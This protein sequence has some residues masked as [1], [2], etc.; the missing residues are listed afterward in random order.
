MSGTGRE[1]DRCEVVVVGA[2]IA[3]SAL[4]ASLARRGVRVALLERLPVFRDLVRG[5]M[6]SP[7]GVAES[8]L[9]GVENDLYA[10]NPTLLRKWVQW[11][12][13]HAPDE[14]PMVDLARPAVPG[15]EGPLSIFHHLTCERFTAVAEAA[16]ARVFMGVTDLD[17]T[18]GAHPS[19][20]FTSDGKHSTIDTRLVVGAGG[21]GGPVRRQLGIEVTRSVHHWGAG[22]AVKGLDDW[23][24]GVQ[25][26]GTEGSR[27]FFVFP[28][29]QGRA[30]LYLNF[31]TEWKHKCAGPD[32]PRTFLKLFGLKSMPLSEMIVSSTPVGPCASLPS[33]IS[34]VATIAGPGFVLVGDEAGTNDTVLGTGLA[35][36]LRDARLVAEAVLGEKDW[37][38][39][40]FRGY[41]TER[42]QRMKCLH[43]SAAIV[44]NLWATFGPEATERR[45]RALQ[46]ARE[47]PSLMLFMVVTLVGPDAL[48]DLG[49]SEVLGD[50][51]LDDD[52]GV[53][54]SKKPRLL[55][56]ARR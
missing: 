52:D 2:G 18:V 50:R 27:M 24:Q 47:N 22:L 12:E 7:W 53:S 15:V 32:G 39:E 55:S 20:S 25:A 30:R 5:E 38:A 23:P 48:P 16:G 17:V 3:G 44:A 9:L 26:M 8:Q 49:L 29:S 11:D 4:A 42:R 45:R 56:T 34:D 19:V 31:P 41:V 36:S 35:S 51:L 54:L 46:R 40:A 1:R 33:L 28:Q 43:A 13:I 21:R 37:D 10:V 14:A 6:L